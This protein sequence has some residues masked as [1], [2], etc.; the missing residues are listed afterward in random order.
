MTTSRNAIRLVGT[1]PPARPAISIA[2]AS[3][4]PEPNAW[5]TP[6]ARNDA[7]M[8]SAASCTGPSDCSATLAMIGASAAR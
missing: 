7:T 3:E 4:C 8:R 5:T 2:N 1:S 6:P